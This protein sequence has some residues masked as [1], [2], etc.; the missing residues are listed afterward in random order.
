VSVKVPPSSRIVPLVMLSAALI[1]S[2]PLGPISNVWL[3]LLIATRRAVAVPSISD[4]DP[5]VV[6]TAS[7][8]L[9]SIVPSTSSVPPLA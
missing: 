4:P 8:T 9:L 7:T 6:L 1:V 2:L 3:A 5:A